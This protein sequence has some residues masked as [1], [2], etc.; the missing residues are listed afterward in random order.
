MAAIII[1]A[2]HKLTTY[3]TIK[4]YT[5]C[6]VQKKIKIICSSFREF[7]VQSYDSTAAHDLHI[8]SFW[9]EW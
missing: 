4:L 3:S 9:H 2:Q 7:L 1:L 6:T 5:P 8:V